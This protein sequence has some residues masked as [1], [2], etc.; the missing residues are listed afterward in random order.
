MREK[1]KFM[2]LFIILFSALSLCVI[3][4]NAGNGESLPKETSATQKTTRRLPSVGETFSTNGICKSIHFMIPPNLALLPKHPGK[5]PPTDAEIPDSIKIKVSQAIKTLQASLS[6]TLTKGGHASME[7]C[8]CDDMDYKTDIQT[9]TNFCGRMFSQNIEVPNFSFGT[10]KYVYAKFMCQVY[11]IIHSDIL[12]VPNNPDR[13]KLIV[14]QY[15]LNELRN[16]NIYVLNQSDTDQII[17]L[18]PEHAT[19]TTM[20]FIREPIQDILQP[21]AVVIFISFPEISVLYAM[22]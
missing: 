19:K 16:Q 6:S 21:G 10:R 8:I 22:H 13:L 18:N 20:T 7:M 14:L 12:K 2:N 11:G 15:L 3:R 5:Q 9:I 1:L 4:V 17:R